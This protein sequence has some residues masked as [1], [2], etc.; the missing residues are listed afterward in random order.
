RPPRCFRRLLIDESSE[1]KSKK[2]EA[3]VHLSEERLT[4]IERLKG[5]LGENY[6][7]LRKHPIAAINNRVLDA[8]GVHFDQER[9]L[10]RS[11]LQHGVELPLRNLYRSPLRGI[12]KFCHAKRRNRQ[13]G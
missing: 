9:A 2:L 5:Y 6:A 12:G 11:P 10:E 4:L 8:L 3:P 7:R 1:L 13:C